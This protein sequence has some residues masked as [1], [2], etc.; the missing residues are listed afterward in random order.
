MPIS[1]RGPA[2]I[3]QPAG[4]APESRRPV[5]GHKPAHGVKKMKNSKLMVILTGCVLVLTL[6]GCHD[7]HWWND[8]EDPWGGH[9]DLEGQWQVSEVDNDDRVVNSYR[10][11]IEQHNNQVH[12]LRNHHEINRGGIIG[13]AII[14]RVWDEYGFDGIYIDS[15]RYMHSEEPENRRFSEIRFRKIR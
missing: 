13:N 2:A 4:P 9:W 6:S 10:I 12:F 14:C 7:E 8:W 15:E 1:R 11:D 3:I 5:M